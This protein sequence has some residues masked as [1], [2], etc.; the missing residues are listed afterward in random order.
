MD[1]VPD[2][3]WDNSRWYEF[4]IENP[5]GY[6]TDEYLQKYTD[7]VEWIFKNIDGQYKHARWR[8]DHEY[9]KVK[10]RYERDILLFTLRWS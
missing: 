3:Y 2:M 4:A 7:I 6:W 5:N 9:I 8:I 10:F 1:E